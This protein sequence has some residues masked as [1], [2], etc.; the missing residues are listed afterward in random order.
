LTPLS[1][2]FQLNGGGQFILTNNS[3]IFKKNYTESIKIEQDEPQLKLGM[4]SGAQEGFCN[5]HGIYN[6]L[7]ICKEKCKYQVIFQ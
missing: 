7:N 2:I 1:T 3:M 5:G 6:F 4:N